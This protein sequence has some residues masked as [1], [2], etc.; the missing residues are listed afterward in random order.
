MCT[1]LGQS[2]G[3]LLAVNTALR[4]AVAVE[5]LA[6]VSPFTRLPPARARLVSGMMSLTPQAVYRATARTFGEYAFGPVGDQKNHPFFNALVD[7]NLSLFSRRTSWL[8]K[9]DFSTEFRSIT[10]ATKVWLGA[11]D[12]VVDFEEQRAF[13]IDLA[14]QLPNYQ[15]SVIPGAGHVMLP[16]ESVTVLK[17]ELLEWLQ[18]ENEPQNK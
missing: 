14:S 17:Q 16:S 11:Q 7:A 18:H 13:F 1:F 2:F 5:K 3:N 4:Q 10:M 8:V 6:L 12:R 15:L 9:R